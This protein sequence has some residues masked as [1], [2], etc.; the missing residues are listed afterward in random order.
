[1]ITEI[2]LNNAPL[3]QGSG[4][5]VVQQLQD[6]LA[7]YQKLFAQWEQDSRSGID[8][9]QINAQVEA[10]MTKILD[11]INAP[12]NRMF[13]D[14]QLKAKGWVPG[15]SYGHD[16]NPFDLFGAS[17]SFAA[18]FLKQSAEW[19]L[20]S[21]NTDIATLVNDLNNPAPSGHGL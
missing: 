7:D 10:S 11:L 8:M 13:L 4:G 1:M 5:T 16:M 6:A 14:A 2:R 21:F 12:E 15:K 19:T 18:D 9:T 20:T 17:S 3:M